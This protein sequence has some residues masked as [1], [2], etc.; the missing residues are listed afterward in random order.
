MTLGSRIGGNPPG[1]GPM[2]AMPGASAPKKGFPV[3]MLAIIPVLAV[4]GFFAYKHFEKAKPTATAAET[5]SAQ[6]APEK[7]EGKKATGKH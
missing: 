1:T 5:K 4:G 6:K 2:T 3:A 7:G